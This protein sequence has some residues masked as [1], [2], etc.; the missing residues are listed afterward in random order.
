VLD[1]SAA[2]DTSALAAARATTAALLAH[3]GPDDRAPCGP[4]TPPCAPSPR[5]SGE[6]LA[7]DAARRQAILEGLARLDRG[8]ATDL[9]AVVAEAASKLDPK[10]RGA[11]VYV[12][13]GRPT[14]GELSL[15]ASCA[16]ASTGCPRPVRI[17]A[18]GVGHE[19]NMGVLK[20]IARGAFAERVTDG[21]GAA[22][23]ALRLLEEAERPVWL[24]ATVD[25]GPGVERVF[26]RELG[27][28]AA[29]ET[30]LVVGRLAGE[31]PK[32]VV[33][34]GAGGQSTV[35]LVTMPIRDDG[36]MRRRWAEGRLVQLLDEGAGRAAVVEVGARYSIITPFTSLYVPTSAEVQK[37]RHE[38]RR[39]RLQDEEE[40]SQEEK[41]PES[42][43][44]NKEGGTGTRAKGEE[45]SM[46]NPGTK[47]TNNRYG[48][49][50][51]SDNV[52]PHIARQNALKEAAEFGMI[53]L[54]NTGAG[55][56]PNAPTAPWGRDD[57]PGND[58]TS[59]RGNMWGADIGD[60]LQ[61][62][63]GDRHGGARGAA[64]EMAAAAAA[65]A[66]A[67]GT[68]GPSATAQAPA[69]ARASAPATGVWAGTTRRSRRRCA[70]APPR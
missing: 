1:A 56:D 59:A 39:A 15:R 10:R 46:G 30:A 63:H 36:D 23:T 66:P 43:A 3:L 38:A 53:G 70:W 62:H 13:D 26:P 9:G 34:K 41:S 58:S 44:D 28:L 64:S 33:I 45:G 7:T 22:R 51:P 19:A 31:P 54:I 16:S 50:G 17:F 42:N 21:H 6:F 4:A 25:L 52:D 37:E 61:P 35:P 32:Q 29:D 67:S 60:A 40:E 69:P 11:V 48:V 18:V 27:A 55:G 2:T 8:G 65:R 57:S 49:K 68:S 12:G 14:V 47:A 24:G 5:S 20:G